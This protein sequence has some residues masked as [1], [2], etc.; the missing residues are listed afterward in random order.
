MR[1]AKIISSKVSYPPT[2]SFVLLRIGAAQARPYEKER[3]I[4]MPATP[5]FQIPTDPLELTVFLD[6]SARPHF[7]VHRAIGDHAPRRWRCCARIMRR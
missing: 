7:A 6:N 3:Y 2:F 1:A 4:T 5:N